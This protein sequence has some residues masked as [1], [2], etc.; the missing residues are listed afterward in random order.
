MIFCYCFCM[1][2]LN[3]SLNGKK[4]QKG[5]GG[6][7]QVW[8]IR[9]HRNSVELKKFH[10]VQLQLP[11]QYHT[12]KQRRGQ[13]AT[14]IVLDYRRQLASYHLSVFI[15]LLILDDLGVREIIQTCVGVSP[16]LHLASE[17]LFKVWIQWDSLHLAPNC[18]F[19]CRSMHIIVVFLHPSRDLVSQ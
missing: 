10:S 4:K 18:L 14:G 12:A 19:T 13:R 11:L 6:E 15:N 8:K 17:V 16:H 5:G 1:T 7:S 3:M 2:S 9:G